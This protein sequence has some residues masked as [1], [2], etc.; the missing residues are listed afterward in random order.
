MAELTQ[1]SAH[2]IVAS[3]RALET[4][5]LALHPGPSPVEQFAVRA[6][7]LGL[8]E[9]GFDWRDW[10]PVETGAFENPDFAVDADAETLKRLMTA[11]MRTNRFVG[12]HLERM[13]EEGVLARIVDRLS[14]LAETDEV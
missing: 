11:H 6:V 10:E 9:P 12:G 8:E 3:Y 7:A 5:E 4:E 14:Q 1:E 13:Q 2:A